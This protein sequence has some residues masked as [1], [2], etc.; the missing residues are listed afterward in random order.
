MTTLVS[1]SNTSLDG[2][3]VALVCTQI[4]TLV[5]NLGKC[6]GLSSDQTGKVQVMEPFT[7][8]QVSLNTELQCPYGLLQKEITLHK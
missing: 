5:S 6:P 3:V 7:I 1:L 8:P 4:T 2:M